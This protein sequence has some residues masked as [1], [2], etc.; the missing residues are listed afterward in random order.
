MVTLEGT[1]LELQLSVW[2]I[3]SSGDGFLKRI[4]SQ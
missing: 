1:K 2:I 4:C 3:D